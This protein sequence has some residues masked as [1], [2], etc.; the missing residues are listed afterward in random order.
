MIFTSPFH[1]VHAKPQTARNSIADSQQLLHSISGKY[2]I[3]QPYVREKEC[4]RFKPSST[5]NG[6]YFK[7][8]RAQAKQQVFTCAYKRITS[9][10]GY[11]S[12]SNN[13]TTLNGTRW[14]DQPRTQTRPTPKLVFQFLLR[15][16][17]NLI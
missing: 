17:L 10:T 4:V 13:C 7:N 14:N 3:S 16:I 15:F 12:R 5:S 11:L 9:D 6:C 2:K 8:Q 1:R